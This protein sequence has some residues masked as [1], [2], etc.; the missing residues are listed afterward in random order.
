[1]VLFDFVEEPG[2]FVDSIGTYPL[3]GYI[4]RDQIGAASMPRPSKEDFC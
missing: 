3:G 1:M 4:S 2:L